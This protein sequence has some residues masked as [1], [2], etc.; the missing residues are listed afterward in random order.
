M[1]FFALS[2]LDI[3]NALDITDKVK[4]DIVNWLYAQQ[5]LPS[6]DGMD[7]FEILSQVIVGKEVYT[8][9]VLFYD[10]LLPQTHI[11]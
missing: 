10:L 11:A 6:N 5:I 3:M 2:G 9:C 4:E 7:D 8:Q 1:L